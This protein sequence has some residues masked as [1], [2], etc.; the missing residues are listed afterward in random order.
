MDSDNEEN[1]ILGFPR[2]DDDLQALVAANCAMISSITAAAALVAAPLP[3]PM[4][5][6]M[7]TDHR[8]LPRNNRRDFRHEDALRCI[9]RDYLGLMGD[10]STPLLGSE[11]KLMFRL[12]RGRFQVLMEDINA[13]NYRFFRRSDDDGFLRTSMEAR[14]LLPLKTLAY[15]VPPHTFIDYF[16]MSPQYA[17]RV[18]Y[19]LPL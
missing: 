12:S 7:K 5:K 18:Q 15:G 2:R 8:T 13:S 1:S 9:Q 11:F 14:L 4:I 17:N 16:Q 10:P 19:L 6:R 3:Q